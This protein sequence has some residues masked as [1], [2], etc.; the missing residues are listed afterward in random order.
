MVVLRCF[1]AIKMN[2][3]HCIIC[4]QYILADKCLR[5]SV[6]LFENEI[7]STFGCQIPSKKGFEK[8]KN[9]KVC[10][11]LTLRR[12]HWDAFFLLK[13]TNM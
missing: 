10:L 3:V 13:S 5:N 6:D 4:N 8:S 9:T 2:L 7:L 1:F 12:R 11:H